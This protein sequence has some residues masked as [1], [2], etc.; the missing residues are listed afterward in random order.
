MNILLAP[1]AFKGSLSGMEAAKAMAEG[2]RRA[3]PDAETVLLP[4]AD[5][6]DGTLDVLVSAPAPG[7]GTG[8]RYFEATVTG[9]L[10][11][12]RVARWGAT[13]HLRTAV[14]EMA[15]ASG[16]ALVPP[17]RQN[18]RTATTYGTGELIRAALDAGY[19]DIIVGLGGSATNDGGVGMAQALGARLL[20]AAGRELPPGGAALALLESI[21]MESLDPRLQ[22][23]RLRGAT[24]VMNPFCGPQGATRVYGPQKGATPEMVAELDEALRHYADVVL[25]ELGIDILDL[26]GAGAAG[27]TGAGL[28]ALLGGELQ[29]GADIVCDA[30]GLNHRLANADLVF[31]GEGRM[32]GQTLYNKA[33]FV[34]AQRAVAFGIPVIAVVGSLGPGHEGVLEHGIE[35]VEP[36]ATRGM[37]AEE[38]TARADAL[39][40]EAAERAM[41]GYLAR[42]RA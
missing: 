41:R 18:L 10:G 14:I 5:G 1:Q 6:G 31:T 8:G 20:D 26:P 23:I 25:R 13:G 9:P 7:N 38:A 28:V 34:V 15:R 30:V 33:P 42:R 19:T 12:R 11:E 17:D 16:L 27:G 2:V 24:D 37:P 35:A 39:V 22:K 4:V 29:P 32:D 36:A 3:A 21:D 40:R